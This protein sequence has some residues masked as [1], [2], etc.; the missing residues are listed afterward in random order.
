[1]SVDDSN[2]QPPGERRTPRRES[3]G[4][5][6]RRPRSEEW[7]GS[8]RLRGADT[9]DGAAARD[10]THSIGIRDAATC[11]ATCTGSRGHQLTPWKRWSAR[12]WGPRRARRDRRGRR[13]TAHVIRWSV[14]RYRNRSNFP[15]V[16]ARSGHG[17]LP[18]SHEG[19]IRWH[20]SS[21]MARSSRRARPASCAR[22]TTNSRVMP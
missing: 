1:M 2:V 8:S 20:G 12:W 7:S 16:E 13:V 15:A 21:S 9:V 5:A 3:W 19:V 14:R 18:V 4:V 11:R 10:S 22:G 6:I 17:P